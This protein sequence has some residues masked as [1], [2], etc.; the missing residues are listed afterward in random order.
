MDEL[1]MPGSYY[2]RELPGKWRL[3]VLDTTE[4]SGHSQYPEASP[5][6]CVL[7]CAANA[8]NY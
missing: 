5:V 8:L 2:S 1:K 4:M 3:L 6:K 7:T